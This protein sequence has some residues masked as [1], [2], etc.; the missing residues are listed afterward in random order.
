MDENELYIL[1]HKFRKAIEFSIN[2]YCLNDAIFNDFPSGCCGD[3]CDLLAQYLMEHGI[4]TYYI[5]GEHY[6]PAHSEISTYGHTQ[7]HAW[8]Q[9]ENGIIIDI[10]GDQF[11]DNNYFSNYN[12]PIYIGKPDDFHTL[13]TAYECDIREHKDLYCIDEYYGI[14][15]KSMYSIIAQNILCE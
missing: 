6:V 1:A 12:S 3:A 8:L 11:K 10:T 13:F 14:R 4:K 2:N 5:C 9:T 15:L 7:S